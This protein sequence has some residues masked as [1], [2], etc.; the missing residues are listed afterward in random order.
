MMAQNR[1]VEVGYHPGVTDP[2]A[3][4]LLR[5]AQLLSIKN[6]LPQLTSAPEAVATGTRYTFRGDLSDDDMH[7]LA[8]ELLCNDVIQSYTLGQ[9]QPEFVPDAAPSDA[10]DIIPIRS[11]DDDGLA[12]LSVERVLFLSLPEMQAIRAEFRQLDRDPTDVELEILA[13][14]WSEHCLH[15]TFK[16][17]VDFTCHGGMPRLF[18]LQTKANSRRKPK[19]QKPSRASSKPTSALPPKSWIKP[20]VLS[21]FVDNAGIVDFDDG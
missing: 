6:G 12:K 19:K 1:V 10:V 8:R 9:M 2:V 5:R 20:W 13:Q 14:T 7:T 17:Q 16:A 11:L 15:K 18:G 3:D 21:A 4:N